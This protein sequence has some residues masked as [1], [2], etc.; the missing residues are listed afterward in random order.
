MKILITGPHGFVGKNLIRSLCNDNELYG[1]ARQ[2]DAMPG[3]KDVFTWDDLAKDTLPPVDAIIHLA[4]KAHDTKNRTEADVYF[5]V[6]RDLTQ[7][8]YD[9][10]LAHPSIRT[11]IFFS[12]VKAAADRV[13]GDVL[14]EDVVPTPVGPYGESKHEA[15][16][17]KGNLNL[18]CKVLSK[19]LP[20]PLGAFENRRSFASIANVCYVVGRLLE[21]NIASGIYNLADDEPLSTNELVAIACE[22]MGRKTRILT[23]GR[24]LMTAAAKI[25]DSLHL[26]LNSE[27]LA[28]LTE[29]YVVSNEK[30]KR[31]LHIDRMPVRAKDGLTMTIRSFH[32]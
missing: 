16:G 32:F 18:L 17:N 7:K 11:F 1:L 25:G 23:F 20:W 24:G 3:V 27:R 19:G 15:E 5:K 29:N 6:N 10:Y 14:T 31:A 8:L 13:Q 22:A 30:I 9:Y 28:K 26:P 2:H 12:S 4:G 21:E